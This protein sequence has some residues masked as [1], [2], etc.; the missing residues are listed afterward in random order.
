MPKSQTE[1]EFFWNKKHEKA[2]INGEKKQFFYFWQDFYL[3]IAFIYHPHHFLC[4]WISI[5]SRVRPQQ[6]HGDTI[7]SRD[8]EGG[9]YCVYR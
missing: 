2:V 4:R 3:I 5:F 1:I 9:I 6:Q 7:I 8:I